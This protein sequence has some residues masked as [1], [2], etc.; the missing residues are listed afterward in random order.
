MSAF[1]NCRVLVSGYIKNITLLEQLKQKQQRTAQN[2]LL[3][4]PIAND[5]LEVT[6]TDVKRYAKEKDN[7]LSCLFKIARQ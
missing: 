1:L 3:L 6:N 4:F 7:R 5:N 2:C